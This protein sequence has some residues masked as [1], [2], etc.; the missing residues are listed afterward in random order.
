MQTGSARFSEGTTS[1][2]NVSSLKGSPREIKGIHREGTKVAEEC[3]S[4]ICPDESS[5]QIRGVPLP[6][7]VKLALR[8]HETGSIFE[9]IERAGRWIYLRWRRIYAPKTDEQLAHS[10]EPCPP[11]PSQVEKSAFRLEFILS[12]VEEPE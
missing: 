1:A 6:M 5:G 8:D 7:A 4:L 12:E 11:V 2:F 10:R 9:Q 3:K